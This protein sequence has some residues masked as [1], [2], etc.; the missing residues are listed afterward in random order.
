MSYAFELSQITIAYENQDDLIN[1]LCSV[2]GKYD[3]SR[4]II[5][6]DGSKT[7]LLTADAVKKL[8]GAERVIYL[9][10]R[11]SGPYDAMNQAMDSSNGEYLWFLNAGD[12]LKDAKALNKAMEL[13][14]S[15]GKPCLGVFGWMVNNKIVPCI[16]TVDN[17]TKL[18]RYRWAARHQSMLFNNECLGKLRYDL[19]YKITADRKL[20]LDL[21]LSNTRSI[22]VEPELILTNNDSSGLCRTNI[23]TKENENLRMSLSRFGLSPA[24]KA[25]VRYCARVGRYYLVGILQFIG[26]ARSIRR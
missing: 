16:C 9:H 5:I 19:K 4:E 14:K 21:L 20:M 10:S 1:T 17:M 12:L 23:I 3:F 7:P 11:D 22:L 2:A 26:L 18:L 8:T 25:L 24:F 15:A 6:K 13:M